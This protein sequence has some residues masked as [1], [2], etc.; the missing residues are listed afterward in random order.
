M[1]QQARTELLAIEKK[2]VLDLWNNEYPASLNYKD[3]DAFDEFL[4]KMG[5]PRHK[6]LFDK[7]LLAGWIVTF[8]R[9][10]ERWFSIIV[11][12]Q[13]QGKGIGKRLIELFKAEEEH[14]CGWVVDHED[15]IKLDG[16]PYNSPLTFYTKLG[17]ELIE[18]ER[19]KGDR[20]SAVKVYWEK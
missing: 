12:S 15:Y 19:Y 14:L 17:F 11:N 7:Q 16:S 18:E 1:I 9:D 6:L 4:S 2:A 8:D 5:S 20:L 3:V 13:L 10:G